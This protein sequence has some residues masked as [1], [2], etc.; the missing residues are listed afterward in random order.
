MEFTKEL[1]NKTLGS[2][3]R[4]LDWVDDMYVIMYDNKL[5]IPKQ[6]R[7]FHETREDAVKHFY[8]EFCWRSRDV[9]KKHYFGV[10]W[11]DNRKN[12]DLTDR[13]IW[14]EFKNTLNEDNKFE[15]IKWKYAK[16]NVCSE[17]RA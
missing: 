5:F 3:F 17:S 9:Y 2:S 10:D 13:Q 6:G 11:W 14:N 15:I 12:I 7:M 16:Q 8:N 4:S 1:A